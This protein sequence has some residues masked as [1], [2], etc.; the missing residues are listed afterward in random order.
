MNFYQVVS[1][2][3]ASLIEQVDNSVLTMLKG[4]FLPLESF[5]PVR[6]AEHPGS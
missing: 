2:A 4:R 6:G 3:S 1:S 5:L